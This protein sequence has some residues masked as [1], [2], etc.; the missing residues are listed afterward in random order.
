[1]D[2]LD[3]LYDHYKETCN[4]SKEAQTRRNK[5]FIVLCI[6]EAFSF[7]LLIRPQKAF[8]LILDGINKEL[9]M[10]L[11]LSNAIIQTLLWLFII[12]IL[13]RYIQDMLYI[14]RQYIYLDNLEKEISNIIS[15]NI[16]T[17]EGDSYQKNFPMV[18]NFIDLFYKMLM[19]IF[20]TAINIVRIR[21]EWIL[22][23]EVT[24]ALICDTVLFMAIFIITWFYFFEIHSKITIFCK[25]YIPFIDKIA[26]IMRKVLKEV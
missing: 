4:L 8:K 11:Q 10:T 25:K 15:K 18:L 26:Y 22:L 2:T 17:R 20:F 12:Y 3:V 19:P 16:F 1:M 21:K 24:I 7:L 14:E 9:D 5:N 6:L 13:I 23:N